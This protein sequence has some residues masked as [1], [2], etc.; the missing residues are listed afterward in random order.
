MIILLLYI[1]D[2]GHLSKHGIQ[3]FIPTQS[4]TFLEIKKAS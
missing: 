1:L 4:N 3:T 2:I